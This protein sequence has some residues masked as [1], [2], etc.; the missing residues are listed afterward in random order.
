VRLVRVP[1]DT[2]VGTRCD[3]WR[4]LVS[5]YRTAIKTYNRAVEGL[6]DLPGA[7]FNEAWQ[8][9]E[10]ERKKAEHSRDALMGHEHE[11]GCLWQDVRHT[12]SGVKSRSAGQTS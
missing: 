10:Q 12:E 7:E 9:A 8:R 6:G 3:E 5:E 1:K 11:H 2:F 4:R